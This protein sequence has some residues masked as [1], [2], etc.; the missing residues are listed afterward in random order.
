MQR[1]P[2][3]VCLEMGRPGAGAITKKFINAQVAACVLLVELRGRCLNEHPQ[4]IRGLLQGE[5]GSGLEERNEQ[6]ESECVVTATLPSMVSYRRFLY[7][8]LIQRCVAAGT[9]RGQVYFTE[10]TLYK[11]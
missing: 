6:D 4:L 5:V 2:G 9:G 10:S 1:N 7:F 3:G 8:I 11:L